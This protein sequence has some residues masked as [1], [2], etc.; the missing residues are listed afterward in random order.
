MHNTHT[1]LK[2]MIARRVNGSDVIDAPFDDPMLLQAE[3]DGYADRV[4]NQWIGRGAIKTGERR[5]LRT[6]EGDQTIVGE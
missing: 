4:N 5:T 1:L 6:D 2:Y 3:L